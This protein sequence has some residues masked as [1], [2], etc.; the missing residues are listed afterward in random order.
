MSKT[1]KSGRWLTLQHWFLNSPAWQS[2][3][4]DVRALYIEIAKRYNGS[5]NGRIPY[6][7]REARAA[8]NVSQ[9]HAK[10]LFDMLQDRG[11]VVPTKRGYFTV[12]TEHDATEWQLTE[13]ASDHPP[14]F[15]TKDFMRWTGSPES[16]AEFRKRF[17]GMN[18]MVHKREPHG[19]HL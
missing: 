4:G 17:T 6:S 8:L 15:A 7:V 12:K 11:F 1:K 10:Y 5:N 16:V 9:G 14:A 13:Y 19:S 3:P 18:R 2:L